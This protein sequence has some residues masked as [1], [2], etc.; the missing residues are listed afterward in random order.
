MAQYKPYDYNQTTFIPV[1]LKDQLL[2]GTLE[3]TIHT[4]VE[5]KINMS[6]FDAKY[7]ND[8]TGCPAYNPKI[9]LKIVL[10]G[11][12]RGKT[13]SRKIEAAC[14]ENIIFMA[15]TCCQTLDHST[16]AAFVTSMKKEIDSIFIDILL[17]CDNNGLLGG[18]T[19]S[20]DG[21]KLPGN[22]SKEMSGTFEQLE[23]KKSRLEKRLEKLIDEYQQNDA[24]E[25][26]KKVE[27][28]IQKIDQFLQDNEPKPG[29][30][31]KENKS[32]VTDNDSHMM[33]TSHGNIQG[34]NAQAI[35]DSKHQVIVFADAGNSSQDDEHASL[36]IEGAKQ[37]L[38]AIGK[39][40]HCLENTNVLCDTSYF[41]LINFRT[42]IKEKINGYIPDPSFR[43]R[44]SRLIDG[45]PVFSIVDF[46]YISEHDTYICP[47]G[48]KLRHFYDKKINGK[49][50][51]RCY[52][53]SENNCSACHYRHRC[54]ASKTAKKRWL[55]VFFNKLDAE[56]A[57]EMIKKID[58]DQGRK[59]YSQRLGMVEP[60]FGNI[61]TQ[62][63]MDRFTLRGKTK[64][65]I[66]W[67]LYC[68]VH[69]IEKCIP[70]L[71]NRRIAPAF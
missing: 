22:A 3:Y 48:K 23:N 39:D 27:K 9:L 70:I 30:K 53:A 69:N 11:L 58:T 54:L 37:N 67:K 43:K 44:D 1:C 18:T 7:R 66:Q 25:K 32:N 62:K 34:Y 33:K 41:S 6:V 5:N 49:K 2:P 17:F 8:E 38:Q 42:L 15:L 52:I 40:E 57:K 19:F 46:S 59:I 31:K 50:A 36:M 51:Y 14:K 45:D 65:N 68:L 55:R 71:Q 16:I 26:P 28:K 13:S 20:I 21:C 24:K 60:V 29:R 63:R 56:F 12:A 4:L 35:V 61:R 64:V 10:F 47:A